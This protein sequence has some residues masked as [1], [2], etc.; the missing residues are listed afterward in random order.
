MLPRDTFLGNLKIIEIYEFYNMPVLFACQNNTGHLFLATWIDESETENQ[1]L[2]TP[3][4]VESFIQLRN[5]D[6][7]LHDAFTLPEDGFVFIV[8]VTKSTQPDDTVQWVISSTLDP[9]LAPL[10]REYLDI[11]DGLPQILWD[12]VDQRKRNH[13][14]GVS[15]VKEL[16]IRTHHFTFG[17]GC[18][19]L[20]E[21][22]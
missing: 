11:P 6:S 4:S 18:D 19:R 10:P 3:I 9:E 5:G 12:S 22:N 17:Y 21:G 15:N 20:Q 8:S 7:D 16:T 14:N 1:W 2:Y 13:D